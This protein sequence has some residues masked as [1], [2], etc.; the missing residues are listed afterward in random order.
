MTLSDD[1][2]SDKKR[3]RRESIIITRD[4]NFTYD[5]D[6]QKSEKK[7]NRQGTSKKLNNLMIKIPNLVDANGQTLGNLI[8]IKTL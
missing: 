1:S 8:N 2:D 6:A 3:Q 4:S 5:A 7:A